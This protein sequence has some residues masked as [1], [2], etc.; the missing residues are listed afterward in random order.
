LA[1][2]PGNDFTI[3]MNKIK[4]LFILPFAVLCLTAT[5][6]RPYIMVDQFGYRPADEKIAVLADPVS[7]F[8]AGDHYLPGDRLDVRRLKDNVTVFSGHPVIWKNGITQETSGDRGWWFDFTPVDTP[9]QYYIFDETNQCSS[10][11]FTVSDNV[12]ENLL[13]AAQKM[14]YYNRCNYPKKL[15]WSGVDWIDVASHLGPGQ[16]AEARYVNDKENAGSARD[17]RGGW[18]DAGDYNKYVTFA[19][20]PVHVLFTAYEQSPSVF[21]DD[22]SIPESGNGI[23]DLLDELKWEMD[24]IIRMQ[25]TMGGVFIKIGYIDYNVPSPPGADKRPRYYGP[26][27]SSSTIVASSLFA[28]AALVYATIPQFADEVTGLTDRAVKAWNWYHS[29]PKS[30]TCDSQEIKSGDADMSLGS[31]EQIA[32]TAAIYL[33]AL[34]KDPVYNNYIKKNIRRAR[35]FNIRESAVY[36]PAQGDALLYYTRM[37][38]ASDSVKTIFMSNRLTDAVELPFYN[39]QISDDLYRAFM[40]PRQYHWG[41]NF[42]RI[43]IGCVNYDMMV[44]S[45]DTTA[46]TKY[47]Q[48]SLNQLHYLHGVNPLNMVYISNVKSLGAENCAMHIWGDWYSTY[49]KWAGNP[50]PGFVTGGP[51]IQYDGSNPILRN[52]A[53]PDQKMYLDFNIGPP[54]NSWSITEPAIYYQ[55]SYIKLLSKYMPASGIIKE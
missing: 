42:A 6:Q 46:G 10:F 43:C 21:G 49:T 35:E 3:F 29:N 44:L 5:A 19:F 37:A 52:K 2:I 25:D 11:P 4:R 17:M 12:Y 32:L 48:H 34:T 36:D 54:E 18:Y 51:N 8:N 9:G 14:F 26:V 47:Y 50:P 38:G 55:A 20:N 39:Y 27:C 53:Q 1:V 24:W 41:S 28:H 16:D 22:I 45:M 33:Y 31:Q 15:P 7:G 13:K 40:P 23:P 30:E